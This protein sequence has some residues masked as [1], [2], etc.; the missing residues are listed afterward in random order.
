MV[1]YGEKG[2]IHTHICYVC[3][4]E[5]KCDERWSSVLG[6]ETT[7][8]DSVEPCDNTILCCWDCFHANIGGANYEGWEG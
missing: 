4:K 8:V 5:F 6:D 1:H 3:H 2:H 7:G